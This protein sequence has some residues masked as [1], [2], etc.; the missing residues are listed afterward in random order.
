MLKCTFLFL[1][2]IHFTN[3]YKHECVEVEPKHDIGK[4]GV[5][6]TEKFNILLHFSNMIFNKTF[7]K[8][9]VL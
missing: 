6:F 2:V 8:H 9:I 1:Y 7:F 4:V 3:V 5:R